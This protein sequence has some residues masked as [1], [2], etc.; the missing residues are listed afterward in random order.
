MALNGKGVVK[1]GIRTKQK[2]FDLMEGHQGRIC[3]HEWGARGI[4][5]GPKSYPGRFDKM[6]GVPP[7]RMYE[8]ISRWDVSSILSVAGSPLCR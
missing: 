2:T 6:A 7:K 3:G 5:Q 4:A 8:P 1:G